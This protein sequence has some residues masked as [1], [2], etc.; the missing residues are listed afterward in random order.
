MSICNFPEG[1]QQILELL[2][3]GGQGCGNYIVSTYMYEY[4]EEITQLILV[5]SEF[6][7]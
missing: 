6:G 1:L 4:Q 2:L 7:G 3:D 5:V